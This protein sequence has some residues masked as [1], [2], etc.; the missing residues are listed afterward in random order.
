M[1]RL[2]W[3]QPQN[4]DAYRDDL[5]GMAG[6][7][8]GGRDAGAER[9]ALIRALNG[10]RQQQERAQEAATRAAALPPDA[11]PPPSAAPAPQGPSPGEQAAR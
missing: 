6:V 10:K 5:E 11:T 4:P 8:F 1:A 9:R 2:S 3:R 7:T